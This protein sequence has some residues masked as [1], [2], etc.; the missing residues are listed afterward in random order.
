MTDQPLRQILTKPEVSGR[1]TKWAV[2]LAEHDI[3]Y[4]PRTAIKV[5]ALADFLAEGASLSVAEP[6]PSREEV[7]PGEPWVLF[8]DGASSKEG[9][10][11]GLLLT[12]PTGEELTYALRFDFSASNN[13]AEYEALLTGLR[14]A[15][16][17]GITAIKARSDSQLV[18]HQVRGEYEAKEDIMKKY[19]AKVREAIA[20]FDVFEIEQV[21]RSQNKRADAL[22]KLAS[23]SF[24]HLNNEDLVEVVKQK[25]I[26]QVQVLAINSPASWM[27]P[28]VDFLCSGVLPE[29]KIETRRLQLVAAKYAYAGGT[30]YRRSY[31]SPWLK[32]VI[33]EEGDYVLGEVHEGLCAAH[34]RSRVLAKKCLLVGYYW[35]SVFRNAAALVQ[36]CRA[37]QVHAPLRHQPTQEMVPIHSPWPFTQW[38]IDLLG[39]FPRVLGRYEQLVVA[40]DYFKMDGSGASSH[41]LWK[42]SSEILL[43]EHSLPLRDSASLDI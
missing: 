42:S 3:G 16:Q 28:L 43:E 5:Q 22:L 24:A 32:C 15:Y 38:G 29:D 25:S 11:A 33:P 18:V 37:C 36:Q 30:L 8:M 21:P 41:Y 12:S 27:A 17:M 10:G 7:R 31:L 9:S 4:Q 23:S 1:M 39:P 2:E 34:V 14:I 6:N 26:D 20:L 13:E 40:I 19:L 35:P